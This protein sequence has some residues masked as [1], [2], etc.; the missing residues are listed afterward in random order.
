MAASA[1]HAPGR[2]A[3]AFDVVVI[4]AGF[5]GLYM[6]HRARQRGWRVRAF[7]T[8]SGVGG[9]WY[10]NRYPG[11]RVDIE[12]FEYSYSFSKE[13]EQEWEWS[14]RYPPQPELERYCNHVADRFGL[15]EDIQFET[16]VTAAHFDE[17]TRLWTVSTDRGE[18]VTARVVV[19]ATGTYSDP[20]RP[21]FEGADEF[22]GLKLQSS[23][24]PREPVNFEGKRVGI[25]G[26]GA[27][28]VQLTPI[29]AKQ[30]KQLTV[31]Q[32]TASYTV[33]LQN[34]KADAEDTRTRKADYETLRKAQWASGAG[35]T[36][37]HSKPV[38]PPTLKVFEVSEEERT[39]VYEERYASGGLCFYHAFTDLLVDEKA[40]RTLETFMNDKIRSR[41]KNPDVARKLTPTQNPVLTK[42]LAGDTGYCEAFDRD[43][44]ELV[45]LRAEPI[46]K[47]TRTGLI[48]GDREVALDVIIFATGFDLG[49]GAMSRI[50]IRGRGGRSLKDDWSQGIKTYLGMMAHGYPNLFWLFGPGS[51]FYNPV[52]LAEYQV[53]QIEK[54]LD[55]CRPDEVVE[56]TPAAEKEWSDLTNAIANMTLFTKGKNYYMGDNIPGKPRAATL[57]L[58]GFPLYAQTCEKAVTTRD[59]LVGTQ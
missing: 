57:F 47:F 7:E 52:L 58:G 16:R 54:F 10:W 12:G 14:E 8:G 59:G 32:R 3:P 4:G 6:I 15:R 25:I 45:D 37:V 53:E 35:F 28:G 30:A 50:D 56:A 9:T 19:A 17:S 2:S 42:R 51:P 49:T 41:V 22:Q 39:R 48:V 34:R 20:Y 44:V 31:F 26:T 43:N 1:A 36:T 40:N 55:G 21:D 5:C 33:P 27:S 11:C 13:L 18:T 29:L 23:R 24:W 38:P 46:Q